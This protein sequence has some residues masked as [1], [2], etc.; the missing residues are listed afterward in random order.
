MN[1]GI[2]VNWIRLKRLLWPGAVG[3][4]RLAPGPRVVA[5]PPSPTWRL[6]FDVNRQPRI[7]PGFSVSGPLSKRISLKRW[8]SRKF[9]WTWKQIIFWEKRKTCLRVLWSF[10][11]K[12]QSSKG[13]YNCT[14]SLHRLYS[15]FNQTTCSY[16]PPC[17]EEE[18]FVLVYCK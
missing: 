8:N 11:K 17:F 10:Q 16:L 9:R 5:A 18:L 13:N 2:V 7:R 3:C 15:F 1:F 6:E 14:A 4:R 12:G